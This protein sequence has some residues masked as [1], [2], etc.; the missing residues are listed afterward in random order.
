MSPG[1]LCVFKGRMIAVIIQCCGALTLIAQS[2]DGFSFKECGILCDQEIREKQ[3][4]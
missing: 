2:R 4:S 1:R 3:L